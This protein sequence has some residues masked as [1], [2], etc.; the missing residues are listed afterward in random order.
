MD[1]HTIPCHHAPFTYCQA[2]VEE[3]QVCH[4]LEVTKWHGHRAGEHVLAQILHAWV[5][6]CM[7]IAVYGWHVCTRLG[8][9][10]VLPCCSSVLL[11]K[12]G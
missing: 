10:R 7:D 5:H 2:V 11:L 1:H 3:P 4:K 6:G 12:I 8:C 9:G